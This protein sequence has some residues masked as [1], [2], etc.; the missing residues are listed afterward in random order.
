MEK[1][2]SIE[3]VDKHF[4]EFHVKMNSQFGS[5]HKLLSAVDQWLQWLLVSN[6]NNPRCSCIYDP[7]RVMS[8]QLPCCSDENFERQPSIMQMKYFL[9]Y[10]LL[11]AIFVAMAA[12]LKIWPFLV[13]FKTWSC[14]QTQHKQI[15]DVFWALLCDLGNK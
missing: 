13:C 5:L 3:M 7:D 6:F 4:L 8:N 12:A 1:R 11:S 14:E 9:S 15:S 2:P 10:F